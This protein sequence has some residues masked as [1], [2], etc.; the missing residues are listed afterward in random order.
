M[1]LK[2]YEFVLA[3]KIKTT[4]NHIMIVSERKPDERALRNFVEWCRK[5]GVSEITLCSHESFSFKFRDVKVRIIE[6]GSVREYGEGNIRLNVILGFRGREEIVNALRKLAERVVNGEITPDAVDEKL[7]ESYL[8]VRSQPDLII[9]AGN[10]IP[11]FL[12]W[13]TIYSEIYFA[14]ID[15]KALRYVDFLRILREYQR[16]E[17]RYGR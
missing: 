2:I 6:N 17:R 13:Q 10:E 4:P 7:I 8:T 16:R 9:K 5:F 12:V 11:E 3:R 14:D 1:L 15:W